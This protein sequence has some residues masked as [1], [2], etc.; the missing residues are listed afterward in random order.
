MKKLTTKRIFLYLFFIFALS[1]LLITGCGKSETDIKQTENKKDEKA[2]TTN[3]KSDTAKME[4]IYTCP[5]H[6]DIQQNYSGKC[7]KCKM[8]LEPNKDKR[9]VITGTIYTCEM[10]PEIMQ[11]YEG[12]CPKCKMDL[13]L[14]K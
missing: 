11:N 8:D 10:H 3:M 4:T 7:P 2:L 9:D 1:S 13:I 12:Q 5:M 14:K 6:P